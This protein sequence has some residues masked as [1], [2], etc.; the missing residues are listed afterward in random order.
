MF[1]IVW[2]V[3]AV[4]LAVTELHSG[5]FTLLMLSGGCVVGLVVSF[6]LPFWGQLIVAAIAAALLLWLVRPTLLHKVRSL[7]GYRSSLDRMVGSSGQATRAITTGDGEV[8]INGEVWSARSL[9]DVSIPAGATVD[10]YGIDG[11]LLLVVPSP[12][13]PAYTDADPFTTLPQPTAF[14]DPFA[15][16][17]PFAAP[18]PSNDPFDPTRPTGPESNPQT[19]LDTPER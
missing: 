7:P 1:W 2:L 15:P 14:R 16:D 17:S 11:T 6:F 10:V 12:T 4:G 8:K 13:L 9:E 18:A 19:P 3:L 5:D